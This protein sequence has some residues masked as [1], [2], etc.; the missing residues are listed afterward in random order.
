MSARSTNYPPSHALGALQFKT[1][2]TIKILSTGMDGWM[3]G[4]ME[5]GMEG[6]MVEILLSPRA[7]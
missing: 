3:D 7:I 2:I 5:G 1:T 4:W 6:G